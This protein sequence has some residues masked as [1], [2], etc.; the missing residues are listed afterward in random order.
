MAFSLLKYGCALTSGACAFVFQD[1]LSQFYT[2]FISN[3]TAYA[4]TIVTTKWDDDWDRRSHVK[5]TATRH[6][7]L[8]RHG[9]YNLKGATPDDKYLTPLGREQATLTGQ[10]LKDLGMDQ[11]ISVVAE[12][13]MIRAQETNKLICQKLN[14]DSDAVTFLTSDLLCEGAPVEPD[15]PSYHW[16]PDPQDFHLDGSRI[17]TAFRKFLHRADADQEKDSVE[18]FV[19][20]ANVIRYFVCRALQLP[21]EAWLRMSIRHA[22]ITHLSIRPNGRVSLRALGDAGHLPKDKLTFE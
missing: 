20:H 15:P 3:K 5:S 14:L 8:V 10:R 4:A 13:S 1:R 19:C 16:T 7:L 22:S 21:P 12:S 6:I 11:K 18:L 9:Q 2:T 17:E